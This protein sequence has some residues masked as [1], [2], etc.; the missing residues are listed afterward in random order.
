MMD[1]LKELFRE[2]KNPALLVALGAMVALILLL[3]NV[4][5]SPQ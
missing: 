5:I 3:C 2:L 4:R 1:E